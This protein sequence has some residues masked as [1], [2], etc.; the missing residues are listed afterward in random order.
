MN[1]ES[2][3]TEIKK[4]L[5]T[6]L[7]ILGHGREKSDAELDREVAADMAKFRVRAATADKRRKEAQS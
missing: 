5:D 3:I 1:I 2:E 4:K 7:S 6:V